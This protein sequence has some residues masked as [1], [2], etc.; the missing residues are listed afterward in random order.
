MYA[1][2]RV[3][4]AYAPSIDAHACLDSRAPALSAKSRAA[5]S[6]PRRVASEVARRAP[7]LVEAYRWARHPR[8]QAAIRRDVHRTWSEAQILRGLPA[9]RG[10][11]A[12]VCLYRDNLYESKLGLVLGATLRLEGLEPVVSIP[13][14]RAARVVSHARAFGIERII[15]QDEVELSG[16]DRQSCVDAVDQI[17]DLAPTFD[18]LRNWQLDGYAAG[19]HVLSTLIRVTLEGAPD[20][21]AADV[22]D[23]LAVIAEDVV[24]NYRRAEVLLD[25][26]KP[27]LVLVGEANYSVN[28]PLVDVAVARGIDVIQVIDIWRDD[29]LMSKRL[30]VSTRRV[31][32]KSVS[33]ETFE[34]VLAEPWTDRLE[35]TLAQDFDKRYGGHW[36]LGD[37]FQPST[38]AY[39]P[40]E[41]VDELDLDPS[42]PTAVI[43]AHV[44]WD[45]SLFFG[46]D[47]FDNYGDWLSETFV[48]AIGND[49][50]NWVTKAHPSNVFR[51]KH[52]DVGGDSAE[53]ALLRS[54]CTDL[55]PH[56]KVLEPD[57]RIS[58][59]SLYE[60]A[61]FGVTVRGTPGLEMAC[62]GKAVFTA[63][64]GSYSSL[65]FTN[66]SR[67]KE[68]FLRY[69]A[70]IQTVP[71]PTPDQVRRAKAYAYALFVLRPWVTQGIQRRFDFLPEGWHPLD[72]NVHV[73]PRLEHRWA[74]WAATC[75]ETDHVAAWMEVDGTGAHV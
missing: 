40:H 70:T 60:F 68:E 44:L 39:E 71:R 26:L 23:H 65:G 63:G 6:T 51:S 69:M 22:R 37:Q 50:V 73:E 55:P 7:S 14:R 29:A 72:R 54:L 52:G 5:R 33:R 21:A 47:L 58:T 20:L 18:A 30:T 48:A 74:R 53:V 57:T 35:S 1:L 38:A 19:Y 27:S 62:F 66:D 10:G 59:R 11:V 49:Q 43:F 45:A 8:W 4:A 75:R 32:A 41:I 24:T 16:E 34:R 28:G 67:T 64:T 46:D 31:D 56:M 25:N 17:L 2:T 9:G 15:A 61:E 3:S 13:S 42:K 36:A 12:L